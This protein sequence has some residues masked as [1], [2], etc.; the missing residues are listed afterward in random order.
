[1]LL[2]VA[3]R[4]LLPEEDQKRA[5]HQGLRSRMM[6]GKW[7]DDLEKGL[8]KHI[9]PD[10][11][12]NWGIAEMS[13]NPFGSLSRQIG[14]VLYASP[15][16]PRTIPGGEG[17]LQ[18]VEATGYWQLMQRVSTD[19]VG[20]RENMT[21]ADWT[22]R[23]GLVHR[24]VDP[25]LCHVRSLPEAPDIPVAIEEIQI[26]TD[27]AT[28][29]PAWCWEV[30]DVTDLDQPVQ[31]ILSADRARD[32]TVDLLKGPKSGEHYQYR[33]ADE[34]PF[35][36]VEMYHA[37]KTGKLWDSYYGIEAVLG[38]IT[39]GVLCTF[40]VHGV[41]DG[42]FATVLLAGGRVVGL[43]IT[44][45]GG[46]RTQ[47]I[48]AEPGSIIEIA[49]APEYDGQISAIQLKPGFDPEVLMRAIGMFEAGL[50]EYAGVSAADL[51]RTGADPRSGAS[52]SI[53]REGLR[54]AQA[55]FEPQLRRGDLNMLSISA[56][57][58]NRA[59]G[60]KFPETGYSISYPSLPLSSD[61]VKSQREDI[62]AKVGAG[63]LSKVDGFMRLHPGIDRQQA[64]VELQRIQ[65]ENAMF[66]G[67]LPAAPF[68]A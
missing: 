2:D 55:R 38:T 66:P 53:S 7:G 28:G 24:T 21:R 56:K 33:G 44:S 13:R 31:K 30:L 5:L 61:E 41:K 18:S 59:T 4:P 26:R 43:E 42:S 36:P 15:P 54:N 9:T 32:W 29:K 52:L 16:N 35:I 34:R 57:V 47:V 65:R 50:A 58:L 37:E 39:V 49:P 51:I 60:S 27:P 64:I 17:L 63:L 12:A 62:L 1:M 14:G 68:A 23:N 8:N 45:P 3:T 20:L 67:P 11:R 10:R 19:L 46:A 22:P 48:S 6:T 25:E 40:W